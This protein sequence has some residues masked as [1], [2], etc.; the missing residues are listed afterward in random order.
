MREHAASD[1]PV[2]PERPEF[3]SPLCSFPIASLVTAGV[4]LLLAVGEWLVHEAGGEVVYCDTD[5][6]MVVATEHGGF[7]P[8]EFGPYVTA[9]GRRAVRALA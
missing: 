8:C 4:R 9:D 7:V 3:H 1:K 6:L 5:S 2:A